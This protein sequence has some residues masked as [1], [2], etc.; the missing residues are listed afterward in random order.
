MGKKV[1]SFVVLIVLLVLTILY[2]AVTGSIDVSMI[3]LVKGL[4]IGGSDDVEVIKDLRFP[5]IIIGLLQVLL[6]LYLEHCYK[7]LCV[8]HLQNQE[9]S[10][11]RLV[12]RSYRY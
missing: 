3:D 1:I 2:S 8:I 9:L 6:Y 5:R 7:L 11:C 4:F 12:L 10:E